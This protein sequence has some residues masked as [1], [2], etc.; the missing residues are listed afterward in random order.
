MQVSLDPILQALERYQ[1][2]Y[3]LIDRQLTVRAAN[4]LIQRWMSERGSTWQG[5][6]VTELF[7]ELLGSEAHLQSLFDDGQ[8]YIVRQVA[9]PM[10]GGGEPIYFD[11]WIEPAQGAADLL[12]LTVLDVT[13]QTRHQRRIQQQRNERQLLAAQLT[14]SKDQLTYLLKHFVPE[15]VARRLIESGR[16]PQLGS[17]NKR[18]ATVL[19][20]DMRGFTGLAEHLTPE[21]VLDMLND[22]LGVVAEAVLRHEGTLVQVVG[23]MVMGVFNLP[24]LQA[25]HPQRAIAAGIDVQQSLSR[26]AQQR[27]EEEEKPPVGFGIGIS[28]GPV[29]AGYLGIQQ[30]YRYAV[31]G[32][33]TNVAFYLCSQAAVGQIILC[34][35]TV[36]AF[37]RS[38]ARLPANAAF[39]PLGDVWPKRRTQPVRIFS[40]IGA[41]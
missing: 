32:D 23:D 6:D 36:N 1:I 7:P 39:V 24:G 18:E 20:A 17:E 15:Q 29:V 16:V 2:G 26:Y 5:L 12:L 31:V 40:L 19:F 4:P 9:R 3:L 25:D 22:Y 30:R 41:L 14:S 28:T 34:E 37:A 38:G 35:S 33:T 10:E 27:A 8:A 21:A 13:T 11:L